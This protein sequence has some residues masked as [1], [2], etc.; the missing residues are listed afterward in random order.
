MTERTGTIVWDEKS[1]DEFEVLQKFLY[2]I[3]SLNRAN[4][5]VDN[6]TAAIETAERLTGS[7]G[8]PPG[9]FRRLQQSYHQAVTKGN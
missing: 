3:A 4:R 7:F 6:V 8:D 5:F 2:S 1:L 9:I